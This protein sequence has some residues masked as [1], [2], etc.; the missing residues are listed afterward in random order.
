MELFVEYAAFI[1]LAVLVLG[2]VGY[3]GWPRTGASTTAPAGSA[4]GTRA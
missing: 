4:S 1:L 3:A 2:F